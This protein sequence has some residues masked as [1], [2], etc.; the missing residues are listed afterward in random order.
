M[1]NLLPSNVLVGDWISVTWRMGVD[2]PDDL[3]RRR[4]LGLRELLEHAH[5]IES[6]DASPA[7]TL[8]ALYR[9]LYALAARVSALPG[10]SALDD[11]GP[12]EDWIERRDAVLEYGRLDPQAIDDYFNGI[13]AGRF[14]LFDAARPFL[15]DSR[16]AAQCPKTA[17]INKLIPGRPAGNNHAWF[18]GPHSD[19]A[20]VPAAP[21][22]AFFGLITT[23]YYGASGR[24]STREVAG[25]AAANTKAG[26]LRTSLSYH[27][28][29]SSLFQTLI[30]GLPEPA[31]MSG[32]G[33]SGDRCP[34]EYEDY[35]DPLG[36]APQATGIGSLL[37]G[38]A[39]HAVLLMPNSE[40]DAVVDAYLTWAW[41]TPSDRSQDP[42]VIWQ[43]SKEG[44]QY[45]RRADSGRA[46]WRDVDT[47]IGNRPSS[48]DTVLKPVAFQELPDIPDLR[49]LALG[50][51]Q[52]GQAKDT[53]FVDAVTPPIINTLKADNAQMAA[54]VG[55]LCQAGE[56]A[57][58][59][60]EYA[61]KKAW[62]LYTD[63]KVQE[64]AWSQV[65]AAE[66][67]PQA[68]RLFW[69]RLFS[70]DPQ[71]RHGLGKAFR[72]LA[73]QA[74]DHA[75]E[76]AVHS[77]DDA[78]AVETARLELYGPRVKAGLARKPQAPKPTA[79]GKVKV[80]NYPELQ[81]DRRF[82]KKVIEHCKDTPGARAA[83]RSII[84]FSSRQMAAAADEIV[85]S[86]LAPID[87]SVLA[88]EKQRAYYTMA[89]M[90]AA[91]P[92][93]TVLEL[94]GPDVTQ[95]YYGRNLGRCLAAAVGEK[96]LAEAS[97]RRRLELL[98]KQDLDGLHLH[99][100]GAI[101]QIPEAVDWVTLLRDLR[102]WSARGDDIARRWRQGFFH[103]LLSAQRDAAEEAAD[104]EDNGGA[105]G[106]TETS[107]A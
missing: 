76:N 91:V 17:G 81:A 67:W 64:C 44:N 107:A 90:L 7:P 62:A 26:P 38:R 68:E 92:T 36:T 63:G 32:P 79:D 53:Q 77:M 29:G 25:V 40:R 94:G 89:A 74:F 101:T 39:Q 73:E 102:D 100:P 31:L 33:S 8:S 88:P 21:A 78:E 97:A 48:S 75:T 98:T 22:E 1:T 84:G 46:L 28:L 11:N 72:S 47:L 50:F 3:V 55:N 9:I 96:R 18:G 99:L 43:T 5:M 35:P 30:A 103:S 42:Y 4:S 60:L 15:Q 69:S 106:D 34:W 49:V 66:Y 6:I 95:P 58:R 59:R 85:V 57:G 2:I 12:D 86:A 87:P 14:D 27:P 23:L 71:A 65:V 51:D 16:L 82:V 24:C 70:A 13:P 104:T 52:D 80:M 10:S 61:A 19:T 20:P 93:K 41:R 54:N 83:L 37:T 56:I 45:A 105:G